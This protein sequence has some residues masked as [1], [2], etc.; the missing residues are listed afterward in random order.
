MTRPSTTALRGMLVALFVATAAAVAEEDTCS[1]TTTKAAPTSHPAAPI[2]GLSLVQKKVTL[3]GPEA[4][5]AADGHH[6]EKSSAHIM[7]LTS[8]LATQNRS[9]AQTKV[10][11][12][13]SIDCYVGTFKA[14]GC[15]RT[16]FHSDNWWDKHTDEDVFNDM[17]A[18]C[19][20]VQDGT[21]PGYMRGFCCD[22]GSDEGEC[23]ANCV[24]QT[25]FTCPSQYS[26]VPSIWPRRKRIDTGCHTIEDRA[27]CC[28]FKD[29]RTETGYLDS[30]CVPSKAGTTFPEPG[31][32]VCEPHCCFDNNPLTRCAQCHANPDRA[33]VFIEHAELP[34]W[35]PDQ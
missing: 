31:N 9:S 14:T 25:E 28:K 33:A 2:S 35:C 21:D 8:V 20:G 27:E 30:P 22:E 15:K 32:N 18:Y 3:R 10:G 19:K 12:P 29:G 6:H 1:A 17:Y 4:S 16:R 13:R 23:A 24:K 5:S 7:S 26:L 34:I 11:E